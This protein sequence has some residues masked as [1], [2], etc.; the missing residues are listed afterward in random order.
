MRTVIFFADMLRA[1]LLDFTENVGSLESSLKNYGGTWFSNC[2]T[3]APDT[4][5]SMS[6]FF[7]GELPKITGVDRRS[8]WPGPHLPDE[9]GN[10]LFE[11]IVPGS[12]SVID[13]SLANSEIFFPK[14]V[15][16]VAAFYPTVDEYLSKSASGLKENEVIF[17]VSKTYHEVVDTRFAHS[18]S[19]TK[20]LN[21]ISSEIRGIIEKL[22][23]SNGDR[24]LLFSDHGCKLTSDHFDDLSRLNRDRSQVAFFLSDFSKPGEISQVK[25]LISMGDIH[26][27]T[28]QFI[29]NE[30]MRVA[31][32]VLQ[33]HKE[34]IGSRLVHVEDHLA[35][36]TQIGEPVKTW[37]VFSKKWEYYCDLLGNERL[38]SKEERLLSEEEILEMARNFLERNASNYKE[39]KYELQ[40]L[41]S[42]ELNL[43]YEVPPV[44]MDAKPTRNATG[45]FWRLITL[46]NSLKRRFGFLMQHRLKSLKSRPN[47]N[48]SKRAIKS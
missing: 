36:A 28:K 16:Q 39:F 37:A 18:S 9:F 14:A 7:S 3:S 13:K 11:K 24:L 6:I 22:E 12:L 30:T 20:A 26:K 43:S 47:H 42:K 45:W 15:Q 8:K 5:R 31:E 46:P 35:Y 34:K 10:R 1:N 48:G 21:L 19:H 27:I 38:V 17:I 40:S 44:K 23:L 25:N 2:I 33:V 4:P 32:I 41:T 29:S